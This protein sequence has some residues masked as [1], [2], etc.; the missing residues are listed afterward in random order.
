MVDFEQLARRFGFSAIT[1]RRRWM[2]AFG[3]PPGK[4]LQQLRMA[5]ACRL[6]VESSLQIKE[7]A[8]RVGLPDEYY[9]SRRFRAETGLPPSRYRSLYRLRR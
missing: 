3:V 4:S 9:F 5:E 1:F 7:I 2:A 6:L 8:V